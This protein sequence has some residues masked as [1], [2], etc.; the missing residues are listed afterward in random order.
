MSIKCFLKK[1]KKTLDKCKIF[2][3]L[4]NVFENNIKKTKQKKHGNN[5]D[6]REKQVH[7]TRRLLFVVGFKSFST[8]FLN[9]TRD[10][11]DKKLTKLSIN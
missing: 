8:I 6:V 2:H 5:L 4:C 7:S 10:S 1:F 3:Y 9:K 11:Y